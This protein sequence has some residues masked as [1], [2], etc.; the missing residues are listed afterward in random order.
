MPLSKEETARLKPLSDAFYA[1]TERRKKEAIGKLNPEQKDFAEKHF[2][3]GDSVCDIALGKKLYQALKNGVRPSEYLK[4]NMEWLFTS[5]F[6]YERYRD[7][8]YDAADRMTERQYSAG[9]YRRS[10]RTKDYSAYT[11]GLVE[12][13][14]A[15]HSDLFPDLSAADVLLKRCPE[16]F[17][18][19]SAV[20]NYPRK[21]YL[22]ETVAYAIDRGDSEVIGA[23]TDIINGEGEWD[24]NTEIIRAVM[25]CHDPALHQ[26]LCK[27]LKAAKLQEGLRQA[28]CENAD[29]G[30]ADA[31]R[32]ILRTIT[33]EKMLR[34]SSVKRAIGTWTGLLSPD[35]KDVDR[36][37]EKVLGMMNAVLDSEETRQT[38]LH[39]ED[40]M[41][42]F[43]AL[44][45]YGFYEVQDA[46]K[47]IRM[48]SESGTH[49]QLLSAGYFL[50]NIEMKTFAHQIAK[51]VIASHHTEPD[52][53]AV[54]LPHFMSDWS[55]AVPGR[56]HRR[57]KSY[58]AAPDWSAP[59]YYKDN[60][61]A[62]QYYDLLQEL[63]K[64]VPKKEL[65]F[66]PCIFPWYSAVLTRGCI[67]ARLAVTASLLGDPDRTDAF[68]PLI[69]HVSPDDRSQVL[70]VLLY[71]QQTDAQRAALAEALCDKETIT[72]ET[73]FAI[74]SDT[75]IT[76]AQYRIMEELLKYKAA[77]ARSNLIKLLLRQDDAALLQSIERLLG[78]KKE[79][80][81]TAALDLM[82]QVTADENRQTLAAQCRSLAAKAELPSDKE[83]ILLQQIIGEGETE[84]AAAANPLFTEADVYEPAEPDAAYLE[85]CLAVYR[86]YYPDAAPLPGTEKKTALKS[87]M[88]RLAKH[89]PAA[90][91]KPAGDC[92]TYTEA[93][94]LLHDLDDR[95]VQMRT[96]EFT[97]NGEAFTIDCRS[98]DFYVIS[99]DGK[100][101]VP[102][103]EDWE[104]WYAEN[105]CTP[106]IIARMQTALYSG[107]QKPQYADPFFGSGFSKSLTVTYPEQMR[108]ILRSL[109]EI[110]ADDARMVAYAV[111]CRFMQEYPKEEQLFLAEPEQKRYV[112]FLDSMMF[113]D[114][115]KALDSGL[116]PHDKEEVDLR[117]QLERTVRADEHYEP[118]SRSYS[119]YVRYLFVGL[120][121]RI[122]MVYRGSMPE[123]AML[124]EVFRDD[125]TLGKGLFL[126]SSANG[127][128]RD[129]G[130]QR[131]KRG[132]N[133]YWQ[134]NW[135]RNAC[136]DLAGRAR[137]YQE[138]FTDEEQKLLCYAADLF[139]RIIAVILPVELHRGDTP[140]KYSSCIRR[141]QRIYGLDNFLAILQALGKDTLERATYYHSDSKKS[142]LSY[143]LSVCI[144]AEGD[145]DPA[146]FTEKLKQ[147]DI[148]E[149]RLIEAAL[150]APEWLPVIAAHLGWEGFVSGCYYFMAHMNER[151]DDRR[152]AMIAK[153]TPL[154][155]EELN[156]GAFDINW[157]RSAYETLGT[158]HFKQ[159]YDAAK[160]I[161]DGAKHTRAQKYADAVQ[162][163]L[164]PEKTA[165]QIADKRN[166]DLI[167]AYALIPFKDEDALC[168]RYLRIV[169]YRKEAKKFGAQRSASERKAADIALQNLAMNAGYADVMR[170][171]LR[172]ETKL[173]DDSQAYFDGL[174]IDDL[175]VRLDVSADG[176]VSIGVE[177]NGKALKAIPAKY[178]KHPD[179]AAMTET[180]KKL[181][182]QYRRTREM[183]EQAMEEETLWR[184]DELQTLMQNPV[185]APV[186]GRLVFAHDGKF[187]FLRGNALV[188]A[189]GEPL[190]LRPDDQLT[191][192]HPFAMR[193]AG[194]WADYQAYCFREKLVQPFKQVFREL[195]VKTPDE[196]E[197]TKSMRYAGN[198]IQP[199]KTLGCLKTRR[200]IADVEDGLQK[201]F[202]RENLVVT[203][204]AL[205]DWFSPADIES[206]TLEYVA[207]YDRKTGK[208]RQISEVPDVLFSEVMRDVDMAVSVA[209]AGGVDPET[210]HSTVEMRAALLELTKPLLKLEN[211]EI[212][213]HHAHIH[214]TRADYTVHLGSGVVHL[215]GGT[216]LNI[217]P[218]HSQHR[219]RIFLPFADDDPKTAEILSKILLLSED[220][221]IQDPSILAQL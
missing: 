80:K 185:A 208:P 195:Y 18:A 46:C 55:S 21:G 22:P 161:S 105:G 110:P 51:T 85:E 200:W 209:H 135:A 163:K 77:D 99:E 28:V 24:L 42:I 82:L 75:E 127:F 213:G 217:L 124:R 40:S 189:E 221:K 63:L 83:Q 191:A 96:R 68:L 159:I 58:A 78:D 201:V 103:Y 168:K 39:S 90:A 41:A 183:L 151:F 139:D 203:I 181:T 175:F 207:F 115:I 31:F 158:K 16:G 114:W 174:Q 65:V 98:Y 11:A 186:I 48:I 56:Y 190:T 156:L 7:V 69:P 152:R 101:H 64:A 142:N 194:V 34:Y 210:S 61:E 91:K 37:S 216:M 157:F 128:V 104:K 71:R 86:R 15:F 54:M 17:L 193:K 102:F 49:H 9:W 117:L 220:S 109:A 133:S 67:A 141:T 196:A 35:E 160:Y 5:G 199:A 23:V 27:L 173:L 180:K 111:G 88:E 79:E 112:H 134:A 150:Y 202:Y 38:Y 172:M 59:A 44:W 165:A 12:L 84:Q 94:R 206:P 125:E 197:N 155:E 57:F 178:K 148:T 6:L 126:L 108:S 116:G 214:G 32:A 3:Y 62:A 70:R 130:V 153:Y 8:L 72:R 188:P 123:A 212:S 198:Q 1:E 19:Y 73:A 182:E 14:R 97:R 4:K 89:F 140:T 204:Y 66:S 118:Y 154:T 95:L 162:G 131:A 29:A 52:I 169:E 100:R 47:Q 87:A 215:K 218:V 121:E 107:H 113:Y 76:P 179:I 187:G 145:L 45:G 129:A 137:G 119:T 192:A 53:M 164:D 176:D 93:V 205:A 136:N 143:L 138:P 92:A 10:L 74:I 166:K 184:A 106:E 20:T 219:G 167:M 26:Q 81:R 33:E 149:Q 50:N 60:R 2:Y 144:P 211:V 25:R 36:I 122:R 170:L 30:N 43:M 177:K 120:E 171:T 13:I 146:V 132:G 147:T